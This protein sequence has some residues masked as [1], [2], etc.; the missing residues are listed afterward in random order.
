MLAL[1]SWTFH[2]A[3]YRGELSLAQVPG[4]A[5]SLGFEAV[6]LQDL[7]LWPRGRGARL[8]RAGAWLGRPWA[9]APWPRSY[10]RPDLAA[11]A[12]GLQ[13]A[14]VRLAAWEIDTDFF[15]PGRRRARRYARL[16]LATARQLGAPVLRLT[17]GRASH[18]PTPDHLES[19]AR[20]LA[21]LADEAAAYGLTLALEN[22]LDALGDP[23]DLARVLRAAGRPNLGACL[24]FG[25]FSPGREL[26]GVQA[27]APLAVYAHA[28]CW[29]FDAQGQETRL[30]Y[31]ASLGA[32][33]S[34]G[35]R[36][37]LAIE[38]EGDGDPAVAARQ[39]RA[40]IEADRQER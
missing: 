1:S 5:G 32:L 16:G 7:F 24:D 10:K 35:F 13:R 22:H 18:R 28:K 37:T 21:A 20:E 30:D 29:A 8:R 19:L 9:A 40:L 17:A 34:A 12:E 26:A 23:A 3:L 11:V 31:P 6:A 2:A 14:G 39:A 36:G 25:N 27:L 38:Y 33:R 15:G 4:V